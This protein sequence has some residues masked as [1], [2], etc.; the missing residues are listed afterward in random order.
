M[1]E[2][3]KDCFFVWVGGGGAKF[4]TFY[5]Q[6]PFCVCKTK[7]LTVH[8]L[9]T[10]LACPGPGCNSQFVTSL[11][12]WDLILK[13]LVCSSM[14]LNFKKSLR[15]LLWTITCTKRWRGRHLRHVW[16]SHIPT[17]WKYKHALLCSSLK[18]E[19]RSLILWFYRD[20][21]NTKRGKMF[22]VSLFYL[23]YTVCM[24]TGG[25]VQCI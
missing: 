4:I 8:I 12:G 18:T 24:Q 13:H 21:V 17:N 15:V 6:F 7:L 23:S 1:T 5:A 9:T 20:P 16:T 14:R 25:K 3:W 2:R 11:V 19:N 10:T 22:L